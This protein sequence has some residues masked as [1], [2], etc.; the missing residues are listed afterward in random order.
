MSQDR[1]S[2]GKGELVCYKLSDLQKLVD[3]SCVALVGNSL[4]L[5]GTELGAQIDAFPVV[6]RLNRGFPWHHPSDLGT[7]TT[8][9]ANNEMVDGKAIDQLDPK[10]FMYSAPM[11]EDPPGDYF[12]RKIVEDKSGFRERCRGWSMDIPLLHEIH[13]GVGRKSS[14][15]LR[16]LMVLF[17]LCKPTQIT[18]FGFDPTCGTARV[19]PRTGQWRVIRALMAFGTALLLAPFLALVPPHAPWALG[20][21][22]VGAVVARRRWLEH[23]SLRAIAGTCPRCGC[24]VSLPRATRLRHPHPL[25]CESCYHELAVVVHPDA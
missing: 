20:A 9:W 10:F 23:H 21:L 3:G 11:G 13:Q 15:G 7:K 16:L 1:S 12:Y 18:L 14:S 17:K 4:G 25:T 19:T 5:I 22:G 2:A 6:A 8:I 24:D